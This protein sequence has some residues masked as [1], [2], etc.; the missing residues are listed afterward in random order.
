MAKIEIKEETIEIKS[1]KSEEIK[2]EDKLVS[3]KEDT[4]DKGENKPSEKDLILD[5]FYI[6]ASRLYIPFKGEPRP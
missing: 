5:Y 4:D 6:E 1:E 2:N 3:S